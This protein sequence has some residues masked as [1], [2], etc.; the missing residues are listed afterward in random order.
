[1]GP[2]LVKTTSQHICLTHIQASAD[3]SFAKCD[4]GLFRFLRNI[5]I[6]SGGLTLGRLLV[7]VTS[8]QADA[9]YQRARRSGAAS[10]PRP[11][12]AAWPPICTPVG[13]ELA[14][15]EDFATE[16]AM[17]GQMMAPS[18]QFEMLLLIATFGMFSR[19]LRALHEARRLG[20]GLCS[21]GERR[22]GRAGLSSRP[23]DEGS[24]PP[25]QRLGPQIANSRTRTPPAGNRAR[26]FRAAGGIA[27]LP[28][29]VNPIAAA[30]FL[31]PIGFRFLR[32][33]LA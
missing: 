5:T 11:P 10:R 9:Q 20:P 16:V 19:Q 31:L 18:P 14:A 1:M 26:V 24:D 3:C 29:S 4:R 33:I 7:V 8:P 17:A 30:L 21:R 28:A 13:D 23:S 15:R 12:N 2:S 22:L 27:D 6:H 25:P 32:V